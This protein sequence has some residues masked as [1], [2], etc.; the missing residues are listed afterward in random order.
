MGVK[1]KEYE[2]NPIPFLVPIIIGIISIGGAYFYTRRKKAPVG[3][4][5]DYTP[6]TPDPADEDDEE[7]I[8]EQIKDKK[9]E[10]T[11]LAK[12][13]SEIY[14]GASTVA[15]ALG[16]SVGTLAAITAGAAVAVTNILVTIGNIK[17]YNHA[18]HKR[19][20]Y[21]EM[22]IQVAA[23]LSIVREQLIKLKGQNNDAHKKIATMA[24][25]LGLSDRAAQIK[26]TYEKEKGFTVPITDESWMTWHFGYRWIPGDPPIP[27]KFVKRGLG[28]QWD[29]IPKYSQE[30]YREQSNLGVVLELTTLAVAP[31]YSAARSRSAKKKMEEMYAL[32][33]LRVGQFNATKAA[34]EEEIN[35]SARLL[36][37]LKELQDYEKA[38]P[39]AGEETAAQRLDLAK[40]KAALIEKAKQEGTYKPDW[41]RLTGDEQLKI[42]NRLGAAVVCSKKAPFSGRC[43]RYNP[44]PGYPESGYTPT[45]WLIDKELGIEKKPITGW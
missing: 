8:I 31:F 9:D 13:G 40:Q 36:A 27:G 17:A 22:A 45:E 1:R 6:Y 24:F 32:L 10:L 14:G 38:H 12:Q 16:V 5:H 33:Q 2:D 23:S 29:W 28:A 19:E 25:N 34:L 41:L 15:G 4:D 21:K 37:V 42:L 7:D 30:E 35:R 26:E 43:L 11:K 39:G 20:D 3:I 18:L 44:P